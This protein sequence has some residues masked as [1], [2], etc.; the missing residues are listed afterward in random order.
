MKSLE[1]STQNP[2]FQKVHVEY[3]HYL[4]QVTPLYMCGAVLVGPDE[5]ECLRELRVFTRVQMNCGSP[6]ETPYY[7]SANLKVNK[8]VCSFCCKE[9]DNA[10]LQELKKK[11]KTVIP[12][13]SACLSVGRKQ[14]LQRPFKK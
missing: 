4:K 1:S 13:C 10:S 14:I 3:E 12:C 2:N 5:D 8:S 6:I 11:F 7:T 9:T